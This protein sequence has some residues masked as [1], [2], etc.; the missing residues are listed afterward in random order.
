LMGFVDT[1]VTMMAG[2]QSH[3]A[4]AELVTGNFFSG[5]GVTALAGRVLTAG[6]DRKSAQ[7]IAMI[8]YR[9]WE[10]H[11]GLEPEVVGR[12]LFMNAKPVT[13][14]GILPRAFLGVH[15]GNAPDLYLPMAM[16]GAAGNKWY[17]LEDTGS[18]WVQI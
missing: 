15:P 7:P 8:S 5:L 1:D 13:I 9:Y 4:N 18:S 10:S 11:L 6:D 12:T 17:H 14:V 3:Y 16:I 2:G